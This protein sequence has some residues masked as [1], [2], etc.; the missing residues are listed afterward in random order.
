[1]VVDIVIKK[2]IDGY[3]AEIPSIKGCESWAHDEETAL[4]KILEL[5]SFYLKLPKDKFKLDKARKEEDTIIYKLIF[6]KS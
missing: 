5:A 6:H 3:S 4:E 1:M 2:A